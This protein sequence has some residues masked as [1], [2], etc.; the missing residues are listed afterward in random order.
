MTFGLRLED[1]PSK[2]PGP[3]HYLDDQTEGMNR[4]G[5]YS[6]GKNKNSLSRRFSKDRRRT[7]CDS[8]ENI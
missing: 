8:K 6:N 3:G 1:S 4:V 5:N 7:F 2:T